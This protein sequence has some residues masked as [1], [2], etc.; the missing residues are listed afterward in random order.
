MWI[1]LAVL[2]A[3]VE[4][5]TPGTLFAIFFAVGAAVVG[6]LDLF[7]VTMDVSGQGLIFV[8][9]SVCA[10]LLLRKPLMQ[11]LEVGVPTAKVDDMVGETA[12]ALEDI[13]ADAIGKA[14]LRGSAWSARN[15][16]S[17]TI[18]RSGR[19][20]VERIEGLMLYVRGS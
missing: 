12:Q 7:G 14:E 18:A 20:R 8:S 13:A 17:A 2:L 16:G 3:A 4:V 1:L 10:L 19:C 5:L 6:L 9:V 15:I 11:R